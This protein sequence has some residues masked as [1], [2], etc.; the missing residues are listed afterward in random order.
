[1]FIKTIILPFL[2]CS[3]FY[4]ITHPGLSDNMGTYLYGPHKAWRSHTIKQDKDFSDIQDMEEVK[5]KQTVCW[6]SSS[7][8]TD[9]VS[10]SPIQMHQKKIT[11][12][13]L[14][15]KLYKIS[16]LKRGKLTIV[17]QLEGVFTIG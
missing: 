8:Y 17:H 11:N 13:L 15:T 6:R 10:T 14:L 4:T 9:K 2:D 1:M 16:L 5:T 7:G 12:H 3:I